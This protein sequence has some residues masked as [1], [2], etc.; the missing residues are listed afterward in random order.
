MIYF[1]VWEKSQ[2][3]TKDKSLT[4]FKHKRINL[5]TIL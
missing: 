1:D 5:K 2:K 4:F 3:K